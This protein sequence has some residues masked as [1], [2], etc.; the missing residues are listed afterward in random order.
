MPV[1]LIEENFPVKG[2]SKESS[3]EKSIRHGHLSTLHI[4][5]A[6]RPL[7]SSRATIYASL[8]PHV[9]DSKEP[10]GIDDFI[11]EL[12]KWE[13]SLNDTILNRARTAI[14]KAFNGERPRILD[15]FA[16]GGSIPLEALR[17]GCETYAS[18]CNP[19]AVL[20]TKCSIEYPQKYGKNIIA[21]VR[22]WGEKVLKEVKKEIGEFYP[23]ISCEHSTG[24][25]LD[26]Q[27]I[28]T[29]YIWAWTVTC[30]APQC[31]AEIPLMR[32]FWL[33]KTPR[34]KIFLHP[35]ITGK[36]V[37][38]RIIDTS[39]E[40]L[41]GDFD[42]GA[43]TV[44][45]AVASC[46]VCGSKVVASDVRQQFKRGGAGQRMLA[47][48]YYQ[49]GKKGKKYRLA[50]AGDLKAYEMA[51]K[52]LT[53]KIT[54]FKDKW[55]TDPLPDETIP[56]MSGTFNVPIYG[57][58]KWKDL[59]NSRQKLAIITFM[60]SVKTCY[61]QMLAGGW[62]ENRAKVVVTYLAMVL[63]R[64]IDKNATLVV[65]NVVGEKIEHVF[66]RQALG[67][68]WD[69][70]ELNVFSGANGDWTSNLRWVLRALEHAVQ[71]Q[72][73][74]AT[75][76]CS[77][78][79]ALPH[80]DGS[81]D[82]V[83]TDPPYYN[84][85]PYA[86]LS[87][88]FYVW[89]KRTIGDLYPGL[90]STRLTPKSEELVEMISWDRERYAHKT[91][92][93]FE[94]NLKKA[95]LEMYRILKPGGVAVIVYAH[96]TVEGWESV[97]NAL[98]GSG[99]TV[100]ASW[101]ISTE[102]KARLRA[103]KSAVLAS[104]IYIVTRK[105]KRQ[106]SGKYSEIKER[107]G[108]YLNEKLERLWLDGIAGADY[109]IAA[110]GAGLEVFG[111]Y[112]RIVDDGGDTVSAGTLLDDI[113]KLAAEFAV[114]QI[115]ASDDP[116]KISPLTRFYIIWRWNYQ[117]SRVHQGEAAKLARTVNVDLLEEGNGSFVRKDG[118]FISVLGPYE[119]DIKDVEGSTELIDVLH[120]VLLL[121]EKNEEELLLKRL[122]R[123]AI[124]NDT[125]YRVSQ[126]ISQTLP[127][128]SREKRLLDGF[129]H[130][131]GERKRISG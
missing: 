98:T 97:I 106:K 4:W 28:A 71:T 21:D 64:L 125:L 116:G 26:H 85:V 75:V 13:N 118:Q 54:E 25:D 42:P 96:K 48:V 14:L 49:K 129:L 94:N 80:A 52:Y 10:A 108:S 88:F 62:E 35:V 70:V 119:R 82:A 81:F 101:P 120:H 121:W 45:R 5:W 31:G 63:D 9:D 103:R 60:D 87:D 79:T 126:A 69:Y 43:G 86:D 74:P 65:Y 84:S 20:V 24:S 66:G 76:T 40:E 73:F 100:T 114:K 3:R 123:S 107:M 56:L 38:F 37:N 46:L 90:F 102:R 23:V 95:F 36:D 77:T 2:V 30:R 27:S 67:M 127:A 59:F 109:F 47:V 32:H 130:G 78:A 51:K 18:D 55:G 11:T 33:A 58:T 12:S 92:E 72:H 1:S 131:K 91:R 17:L 124:S 15:P 104:S 128:T 50:T 29:G 115:A 22:E 16:G 99:L 8:V 122:A 6:R 19:V 41:T 117:E 111:K 61:R 39:K 53:V 110:I 113:R 83:F 112:D 89:L 105:V 7:A 44:S 34:R 68:T 93:Y 57:F